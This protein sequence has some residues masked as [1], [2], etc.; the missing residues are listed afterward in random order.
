MQ[1]QILQIS[2]KITVFTT[3]NN[4]VSKIGV[5]F[6]SNPNGWVT[7]NQ[8]KLTSGIYNA[9][10]KSQSDQALEINPSQMCYDYSNSIVPISKQYKCDV[11]H[12]NFC[13]LPN[14]TNCSSNALETT[15]DGMGSLQINNS[16][17]YLVALYAGINLIY[18]SSG[19]HSQTFQYNTHCQVFRNTVSNLNAISSV[20]W[21]VFLQS[22]NPVTTYD[23][24]T[25]VY[26]IR[27]K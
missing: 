21:P 24:L 27:T 12:N 1:Y 6:Y 23:P 13:G 20:G 22:D 14:K 25:D 8:G 5:N 3:G 19:T 4:L 26:V 17:N 15:Q 7:N 18:N 16:E 10:I 11:S 2:S 9:K